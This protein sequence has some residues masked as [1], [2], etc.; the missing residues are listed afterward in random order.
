MRRPRIYGDSNFIRR[1]VTRQG[2][3]FT[4][5]LNDSNFNGLSIYVFSIKFFNDRHRS[6]SILFDP[7][8]SFSIIF[9]HLWSKNSF[10]FALFFL[11]SFCLLYFLFSLLSPFNIF[12][13]FS[14]FS[15]FTIFLFLSL[16]FFL[17]LS[18]LRFSSPLLFFV[19]LSCFSLSLLVHTSLV[20]E[21][22]V[23]VLVHHRYIG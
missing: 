20:L 1:L 11:S 4:F 14:S 10:L 7:L 19:S 23:F 6:S 12:L 16:N 13:P 15:L 9:D 3:Y 17:S 2:I 8:R 22:R 21:N 5:V 18:F